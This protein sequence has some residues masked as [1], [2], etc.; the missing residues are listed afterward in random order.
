[1]TSFA[2]LNAVEIEAPSA[3]L[4][5][6]CSISNYNPRCTPGI[7]C[8]DRAMDLTLALPS[9][10]QAWNGGEFTCELRSPRLFHSV[11]YNEL[12]LH[13]IET[14]HLE[15]GALVAVHGIALQKRHLV[16]WNGN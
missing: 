6:V 2:S 7:Q 9:E 13:C 1:M 5:H 4:F 3:L 14:K 8:G 15:H 11:Q 12:A 10:S 16:I